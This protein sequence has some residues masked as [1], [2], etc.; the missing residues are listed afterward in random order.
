[1]DPLDLAK[2]SGA[3]ED[4]IPSPYHSY[5]YQHEQ[6]MNR[7]KMYDHYAAGMGLHPQVLDH[8]NSQN[9]MLNRANG[10]EQNI[11]R[12]PNFDEPLATPGDPMVCK[13]FSIYILFLAFVMLK[14]YS[15]FLS[16]FYSN[17]LCPEF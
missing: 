14:T 8:M 11:G 7:H 15:K 16:D 2:N 9:E 6:Q 4:P 17:M 3:R 5:L 1:M 10:H 13:L 12:A